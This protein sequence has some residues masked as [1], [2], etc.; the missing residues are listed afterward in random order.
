MDDSEKHEE[1]LSEEA[2]ALAQRFDEG[3]QELILLYQD[4]LERLKDD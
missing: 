3:I 1:D 2:L 4:L